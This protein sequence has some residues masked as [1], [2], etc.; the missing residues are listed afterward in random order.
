MVKSA[1][2]NLKLDTEK[3]RLRF[4]LLRVL[5]AL[6][7]TVVT[8]NSMAAQAQETTQVTSEEDIMIS[9]QDE[10]DWESFLSQHDLVWTRLPT[11]WPEAAFLG[12]GLM[13]LFMY[14]KD[15]QSI[16][17]GVDRDDVYDRRD[18]SWGWPA[19]SRARYHVGD[20]LLNTVGTITDID[21]RQD[22]Y[23][24]EIRGTLYT[25]AGSIDFRA[26]VPSGG[27]SIIIQIKPDGGESDCHFAWE[28]TEAITTRERDII[29]TEEDQEAYEERYGHPVKI[30]VDN[31]APVITERDGVHLCQ[32]KL[33]VGG[34]YATAWKE[35]RNSSGKRD[36]YISV[37]MNHPE[38]TAPD[39]AYDNLK[40]VIATGIP[41]L[42]A[43][44]RAWWHDYYPASFVSVPDIKVESY[45]WIQMYKYACAAREDTGIIDTHGPW[46]QPTK[47]PYIT[48]NLNTQ[49]AYWGLQPANRLDIAESLFKTLDANA[50]ALVQ[51]VRPVEYQND[52]S[53]MGHCSQLNLQMALD[54]DKRFSREWGNLLWVC[55]NY[56]LQYRFT[57]DEDLLRYRLFPILKRAVNFYLHYV[58]EGSDGKLHLPTTYSPE[59]GSA[60]DCN[61][62]LTLL[63]WGADRLLETCDILS[64]HDEL[65]PTWKDL[66]QRL[67]DYPK[68]SNGYRIG[69]DQAYAKSHRHYSHL[70]MI[71]PLYTVNWDQPENRDLIKTSFEHWLSKS[72]KLRGYSYTGGSSFYSAIGDGNAALDYFYQYLAEDNAYPNT[73][74]AESGQNIETPLAASQSVNDMLIQSWGDKIRVFPAVPDA[75]D[76]AV[77]HNM[78]AEGAFLVSAVRKEGETKYIRIKSLAGSP[79]VVKT[80]MAAP[81]KVKSLMGNDINIETIAPGE[82]RINITEGDDVFLA[83]DGSE[84]SGQEIKPVEHTEPLNPFGVK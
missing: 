40:E 36:L 69:A 11:S 24:A 23:H 79:C 3:S 4:T 48:W 10:I 55:H 59:Y 32:Q 13:A 70:F 7:M 22:L 80:D 6:L 18:S 51:N 1:T 35:V 68:D 77:I 27:E 26:F 60:A 41:A 83:A 67:V 73:M 28:P 76:N 8:T 49:I 65:I 62:D 30:W 64:I 84:L 58:Y 2:R 61:Y 14:Q 12:N 29:R 56:W 37:E 52:S 42:E 63:H 54:E 16:L 75:W 9:V 72:S 47:W 46:L 31:P 44:H 39:E 81:F 57:M 50:D 20:F 19:I 53:V 43:A 34:G 25:D 82:Y 66:S 5:S 38:W 15:S 17:F 78:R 71:Y 21:M 45:Y 33:Y 74:Y